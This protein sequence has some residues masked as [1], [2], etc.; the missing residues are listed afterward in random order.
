MYFS[1]QAMSVNGIAP[2]ATPSAKPSH[3]SARISATVVRQPRC[4]ARTVTMI[5][6]ASSNRSI[7][8]VAGSKARFA[9]LMNMYDAP[10]KAASSPM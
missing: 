7:I 4:A 2:L 5:S 10:Q 8:M 3:P 1:P 6:D 9:T